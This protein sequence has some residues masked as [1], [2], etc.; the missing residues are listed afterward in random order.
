MGLIVVTGG[1]G[2]AG[3]TI[4]NLGPATADKYSTPCPASGHCASP[5]PEGLPPR[6]D[7]VI[8]LA[9]Y[10]RNMVPDNE[11]F[12]V[13]T[14]STYNIIEAAC[15]LGIRKILIASSVTVY[16]VAFAQGDV[17]YPAFPIDEDLVINP[18]DTYALVKLCGERVVRGFAARFGADIYILRTGRV[19][20]PGEYNEEIFYNYVHEPVRWK[21]HGWSYTDARDLGAMCEA[22]LRTS[23]LGF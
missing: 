5:F 15:K 14:Q 9:G 19:I 17:E 6:P 18:T 11:T 1:S 3:H 21:A 20:E 12:R 4:L 22:G 16:G 13:N 7:A 10:A 8:H 23:G 2:K